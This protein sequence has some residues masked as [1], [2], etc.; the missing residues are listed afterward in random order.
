MQNTKYSRI[1][2]NLFKR[3]ALISL[4][5][6]VFGT[7]FVSA[8]LTPTEMVEATISKAVLART[9]LLIVAS[10]ISVGVKEALTNGV[11]KTNTSSEINADL[12]NKFTVIREY[13]VFC[14]RFSTH[15]VQ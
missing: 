2:V 3:S 15:Q 8:S 13:L 6:L 4:L 14:I 1:T 9:A 10:T 11:P 7:P 12:L 5:V